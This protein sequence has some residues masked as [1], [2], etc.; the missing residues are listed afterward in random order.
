MEDEQDEEIE[1]SMED[2]NNKIVQ[3]LTI[4]YTIKTLRLFI[5]IVFLS[6]YIGIFTYIAF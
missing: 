3:I 4:K 1:T 2:D 6:Y 5:I